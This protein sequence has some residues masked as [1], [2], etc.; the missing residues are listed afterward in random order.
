VVFHRLSAGYRCTL[1][2]RPGAFPS[3]APAFLLDPPMA[4]ATEKHNNRMNSIQEY[5]DI[6]VSLIEILEF[7]ET[8][9]IAIC[10]GSF[11]S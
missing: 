10:C 9:T 11:S 4:L 8:S 3:I 7:H 2:V 5:D 6:L 1:R